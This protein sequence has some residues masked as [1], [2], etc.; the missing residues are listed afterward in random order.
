MPRYAVRTVRPW[1]VR[2]PSTYSTRGPGGQP[3][4]A[5]GTYTT[6]EAGTRS[7]YV[8]NG[9]PGAYASA[10]PATARK[11]TSQ[12]R[13]DSSVN[14][15]IFLSPA[16]RGVGGTPWAKSPTHAQPRGGGVQNAPACRQRVV[17]CASSIVSCRTGT[18][19]VVS[20]QRCTGSVH[21]LCV[22]ESSPNGVLMSL[23]AERADAKSLSS[24]TGKSRLPEIVQGC[25]VACR[26]R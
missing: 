19:V 21:A 17:A 20:L 14:S 2:V 10:Q 6:R 5:S 9:G 7:L 4:C 8:R 11:T 24:D 13:A 1:R 3:P 15:S 25:G 16:Q 22:A 18:G 23:P 12:A 26:V